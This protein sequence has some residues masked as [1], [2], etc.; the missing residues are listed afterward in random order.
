MAAAAR[1]G[2]AESGTDFRKRLP[3][4][5]ESGGRG[6]WFFWGRLAVTLG[7]LALLFSR[8]DLGSFIE[9][10]R[11]AIGGLLLLAVASNSL[12]LVISAAKWRHL[13]RALG[14]SA[15]GWMLLEL[16]TIGFFINAFLPGVIG[17]DVVRWQMASRR[18]GG[19]LKV[20]ATILAERVTGLTA[21]LALSLPAALYM[22]PRS[23]LPVLLM[24]V[25]PVA[26][27]LACGLALVSNRRLAL[28]LLVRA[29]SRGV[30]PFV[31]R[32]SRLHRTLRRF[33]RWPLFAAL[34]YSVLFYLSAGLTFFLVCAAFGTE[35]TFAEAASVQVLIMLLIM[36]PISIGGLGVA[37]AG[38]VYLL[39]L[40]GVGS[41]EA[42][43]ISLTRMAVAYVYAVVGAALL[44][45]W[46]GSQ[47]GRGKP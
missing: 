17:G 7:L 24:V 21:L 35:L 5:R 32:L 46:Q 27:V 2:Y 37:Q 31:R 23:T 26:I 3:W 28:S 20:A 40:L 34:G 33:P 25:V 38:D 42:L 41:A 19:R 9:A 29:R 45:R 4:Q 14:V 30:R 13:L 39:G 18:T 15:S 12:A 44:L 16:Y 10:I 22:L 8:I 43:G 1:E 36:I 11:G 47:A 6:R